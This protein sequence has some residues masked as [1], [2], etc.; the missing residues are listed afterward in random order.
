M[1]QSVLHSFLVAEQYFIVYMDH[2]VFILCPSMDI[3]VVSTFLAAMNM[4]ACTSVCMDIG[5]H[6]VGCVPR[7]GLAEFCSNSGLNLFRNCRPRG[8]FQTGV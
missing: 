7:N 4:R 2:T 3:W 1:C 5:L 6:F 8:V